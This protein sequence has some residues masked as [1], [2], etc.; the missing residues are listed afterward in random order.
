MSIAPGNPDRLLVAL[1]EHLDHTVRLVI[2]GR[3]A[4]WLGFDG[5]PLEVGRTRDVDG[6]L[7]EDD[8][9]ALNTDMQFW[10][11][12][13][14]VHKRFQNEG[15]YI[16][17]LFPATEVFLR[18]NWLEQIIP[19]SRLRLRHLKLFRPATLDLVLTKM[20]RGNDPQDMADAKFMIEHD[21][22]TNAQLEAA[23][24]EMKP[25]ELVE[26]REAFARAKP[27]VLGM[28]RD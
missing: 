23:F 2:Y 7:S 9:A 15:L 26:L 5:V 8:V 28:A 16:T 27:L 11:A 4:V 22:I 13:D 19:V 25:I 10:D 24:A 18:R 6:I 21:G 14:A 12:R 1:D 3:A 17:H 20:M